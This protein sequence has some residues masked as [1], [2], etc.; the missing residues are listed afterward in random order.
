MNN[1]Q[2]HEFS[3]LLVSFVLALVVAI[4][5]YLADLYPTRMPQ[6]RAELIEALA[7]LVLASFTM[8]SFILLVLRALPSPGSGSSSLPGYQPPSR[9]TNVAERLTQVF[10][11]VHGSTVVAV[12]AVLCLTYIAVRPPVPDSLP[13]PTSTPDIPTPVVEPSEKER[14]SEPVET[15]TAAMTTTSPNHR[16]EV[17]ATGVGFPANWAEN[18]AQREQSALEAAKADAEASLV[19]WTHGAN[20][21]KVVVVNQGKVQNHQIR[22]FVE[23][24]VRGATIVEQRYDDVTRQAIVTMM[25]PVDSSELP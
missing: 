24:S 23:G 18:A 22:K 6:T 13:V 4:A 12:T 19:E 16:I 7:G 25:I 15:P 8:V 14:G 20:I 21:A 9:Q 5:W 17:Y 1:R 11:R 10:I 2:K 3:L